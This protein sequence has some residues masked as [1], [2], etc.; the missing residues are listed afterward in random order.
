MFEDLKVGDSVTRC[1]PGLRE[2][3]ERH[4]GTVV[5]VTPEY[6]KVVIN[7]DVPR[8]MHFDPVTGVNANGR[9]YGWLEEPTK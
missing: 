7:I 5:E 3:I 2:K 6:I 9:Q 1:W 4:P 8:T